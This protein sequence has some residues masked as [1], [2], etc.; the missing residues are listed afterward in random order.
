MLALVAEVAPQGAAGTALTLQTC[1]GFLLAAV[2]IQAVPAAAEVV[3]WSWAF[4][5]LTFGP[6]A[7]IAAIRRFRRLR[8]DGG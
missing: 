4:A 7:G 8:A 1:L 6:A 5:L 2:T 3:G